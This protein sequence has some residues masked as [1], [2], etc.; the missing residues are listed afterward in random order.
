MSDSK[1]LGNDQSKDLDKVI[2]SPWFNDIYNSAVKFYERDNVLD[3]SDRLELFKIYQNISR[4]ELWGGWLGFGAVFGAPFAYK[5]YHTNSIKGVKVPRN[6]MIGLL[7]LFISTPLAGNYAYNRN[8]NRLDPDGLFANSNKY[9]DSELSSFTQDNVAPSGEGQIQMQKS[10][11]Q[12]QYDMLTLLKNSKPT[13]WAAYFYM[14][15]TDPKRRFPNPKEKLEE[16]KRSGKPLQR[17]SFLNQRDPMDLYTSSQEKAARNQSVIE[18]NGNDVGK[19][20]T[21]TSLEQS[22]SS[23]S[24]GSSWDNVRSTETLN[25]SSWAKVRANQSNPREVE[26]NKEDD[27]LAIFNVDKVSQQDFDSIL[28]A[29]RNSKE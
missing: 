7:A 12:R 27:G 16:M 19:V 21:S 26:S 25:G 5:Y 2:E 14:T 9:G 24:T 23:P 13:M 17:Q 20:L 1:N 6:F 3:S 10:P 28:E 29:E 15:H 18:S 22:S 4:A 8:V 11:R